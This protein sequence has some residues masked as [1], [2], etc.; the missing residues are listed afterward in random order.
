MLLLYIILRSL[1]HIQIDTDRRRNGSEIRR[2]KRRRKFE[3]SE[4]SSMPIH[5]KLHV[6]YYTKPTRTC[7]SCKVQLH[8]PMLHYTIC[9]SIYGVLLLFRLVIHAYSS[10]P[11]SLFELDDHPPGF[12]F[13]YIAILFDPPLLT[14]WS[15][16]LDLDRSGRLGVSSG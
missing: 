16:L 12:L 2:E 10:S 9:S 3:V 6:M 4:S 11:H 8:L 13:P 14:F 1:L 5:A 7:A 15:A